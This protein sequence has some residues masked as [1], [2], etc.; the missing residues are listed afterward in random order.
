[1]VEPAEF[2]SY[3]GRP[4]L[5]EP[6]WKQP[7]VPLY[8][9]LGGAAGASASIAALAD[10]TGRPELARAGRLV[11]SGGSIASVAALIHDLGK[12]TRFLHMLRVLKPT[13]PLS[14][15]SW[16]L[17]PFSGLAAVAAASELS[18]I[19][20]GAGR[21]AGAAAGLLGPAMCT[22][23]AVLLSD[24]ATPSWH[25]AY[26]TLPILFAGS[27]L[28]SGA[29]AALLLV[30]SVETGP[31][32]RAGLIGAA[33]ELAAARHAET[34]LGLASEPYRTGRAGKL[35]KAARALT[36]AGA[37]L[38]LVARRNRAAGAAAGVAYLAAGLCTR[39]GVYA[40]GVESARDPKYVVV[41]QRERLRR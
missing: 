36:A 11:A 19:L 41:P 32:V 12:P 27:A 4:I 2:R 23:T 38:S 3:Y 30:P 18:G 33:A 28:T 5:K 16:I 39:F 24:T 40:A 29:G 25:E 1:M 17:S 7:D 13:S 10:V 20:P 26:G 9:F 34:G 35:L 37:G 31:V 14:V 22:Y 15:G 6:A 8:L 21:L